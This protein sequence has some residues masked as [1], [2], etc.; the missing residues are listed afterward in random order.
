MAKKSKLNL[1]KID[2]ETLKDTLKE[3]INYIEEELE[4]Y[5]SI[6]SKM[7]DISLKNIKGLNWLVWVWAIPLIIIGFPFLLGYFISIYIEGK[8]KTIFMLQVF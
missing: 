2:N 6:Q 5:N 3:R 8:I 1:D 4:T 7:A